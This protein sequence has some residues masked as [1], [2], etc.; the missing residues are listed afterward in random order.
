MDEV[1]FWRGPQ[2]LERPGLDFPALV[3]QHNAIGKKSGLCHI[4]SH[5]HN[6]LLQA[7]ENFF[8]LILQT[9]THHRI[10]RAEWFIEEQHRWFQ[11]ECA[12]EPRPL[13]WA[14]K[15][16]VWIGLNRILGKMSQPTESQ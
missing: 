11:H 10:K 3:Q 14:S 6:R 12:Y 7:L 1:R 2:I 5:H 15:K 16:F 13:T 8:Q 9:G 4:M